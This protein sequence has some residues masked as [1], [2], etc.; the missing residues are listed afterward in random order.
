M[1]T[2][3]TWPSGTPGTADVNRAVVIGGTLVQSYQFFDAH[4]HIIDARFPLQENQ[5]FLP[6][7]FTVDAYRARVEGLGVVGGAV[8]SG[9]FQGFDQTYLLDALKRL[10]PGFVGV[11]Q[12]PASIPD[13]EIVHLAAA[14]VRGVRFNLHRGGS[15]RLERLDE[16]ARRVHDVAGLHTEVYVDGRDL[17]DLGSTLIRLPAVSIDHLGLHSDGVPHLLEL[18]AA[19]ARVKAT[20]FG[21]IDLDVRAVLTALLE[22]D[23]GA[24]LVG[25]DLPSTRASRPFTDSDLDVVADVAGDHLPALLFDNSARF[26]RIPRIGILDSQGGSGGNETTIGP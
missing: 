5:G 12:V 20:G 25:T 11:T 6:D 19:G 21:R 24:V 8:V 15:E 16:F 23:P 2:V 7:E 9:S 22:V 14:G 4:L 18:V 3:S 13:D 10:G 1:L 26:Y 17:P